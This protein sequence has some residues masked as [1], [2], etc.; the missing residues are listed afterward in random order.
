M[1]YRQGL[2]S[3][4][5]ACLSS[6]GL[7]ENYFQIRGM[8][9]VSKTQHP[10]IMPH[11]ASCALVTFLALFPATILIYQDPEKDAGHGTSLVSF[12]VSAVSA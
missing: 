5:S 1:K 3:E 12:D 4:W 11:S 8:D 7:V 9:A 2:V 10:P 6:H